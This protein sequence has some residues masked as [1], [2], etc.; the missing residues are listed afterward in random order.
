MVTRKGTK[1]QTMNY[2]TLHKKLTI[3]EYEPHLKLRLNL[4]AP[5]G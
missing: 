3:E 4:G 5:D 1:E 2:K